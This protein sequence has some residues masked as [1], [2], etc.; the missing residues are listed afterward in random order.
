MD[1]NNESYNFAT[2]SRYSAL[3]GYSDNMANYYHPNL[4]EGTMI[5]PQLGK[6]YPSQFG[7]F[8]MHRPDMQHFRGSTANPGTSSNQEEESDS[9]KKVKNARAPKTGWTR[10]QTEFLLRL[11]ADNNYYIN[12]SHSRKAWKRVCKEFNGNFDL[13]RKP[14]SLKRKVR[15]SFAFSSLFYAIFVETFPLY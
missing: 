8:Q 4:I 15:L 5:R 3:A 9:A 10:E 14:D 7:Q 11:W 1:R 6:H 12:S 2:N 13:E